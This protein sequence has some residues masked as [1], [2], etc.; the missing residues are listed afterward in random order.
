[1]K[2]DT[3]PIG[4]YGENSYV[5]HDNGHV[6]FID[7]GQYAKEIAAHVAKDEIVDGIVLTHGHEDHTGAADDLADLFHCPVYLHINDYDMVDPKQPQRLYCLQVYTP[8]TELKEGKITIGTFPVEIIHTPGHTPGSVCIQYRNCLFTGDTLFA[9]SIG[10]TDL[11]GGDEEEMLSSLRLLKEMP[12]D[13]TVYPGHDRVT[14]LAQEK[15]TN[16]YLYYLRTD[17]MY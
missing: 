5:L 11:E 14:T 6:L 9:G 1:M 10:R 15:K 12:G 16:P 2:V 13:L 4:L 7:P 3:L 8:L 17:F